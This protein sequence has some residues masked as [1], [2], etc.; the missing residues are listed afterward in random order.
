MKISPIKYLLAFT[1]ICA[2]SAFS[3]AQDSEIQKKYPSDRKLKIIEMPLPKISEDLR[4]RHIQG[5]IAIRVTLLPNSE[6]GNVQPIRDY[7]YLTELVVEAAK[8]IKFEPEIKNGIATTVTTAFQYTFDFWY[9]WQNALNHSAKI[10]KK[11][12]EEISNDNSENNT[13]SCL[14]FLYVELLDTKKIGKVELYENYCRDKNFAEKAIELARKIEFEP[15][16]KDGKEATSF[17]LINFS[18]QRKKQVFEN[19]DN[20][21]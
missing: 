1:L 5:T 6:I 13:E 19:E 21:Y 9:G 3:F 7:P 2:F 15:A 17:D 4:S 11:P 14:V 10:L 8:K 16:L 18:F 20:D 12:E